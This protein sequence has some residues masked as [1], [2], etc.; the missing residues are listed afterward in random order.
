MQGKWRADSVQGT[1]ELQS[2]LWAENAWGATV[3]PVEACV[4]GVK[5][6]G[7]LERV[8]ASI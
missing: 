3:M 1:S 5:P 8:V 6:E 2:N 4:T 7:E